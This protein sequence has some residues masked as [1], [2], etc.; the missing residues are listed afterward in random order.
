MELT[1]GNVR[2]L[3]ISMNLRKLPEVIKSI[4]NRPDGLFAKLFSEA[5]LTTSSQLLQNIDDGLYWYDLTNLDS[6]Q[7]LKNALLECC[8]SSTQKKTQANNCH[9]SRR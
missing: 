6:D 1:D 3:Q 4:C 2:E 7:W 5:E 8:S 9:Y